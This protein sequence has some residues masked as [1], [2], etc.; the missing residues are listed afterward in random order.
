MKRGELK[1]YISALKASTMKYVFNNVMI[2]DG[3][4]HATN[5]DILVSFNGGF[6]GDGCYNL[7]AL[8]FY[9]DDPTLDNSA[10]RTDDADQFP[11]PEK[12]EWSD[13]ALITDWLRKDMLEAFK[14][15][16][17]DTTR[18]ALQ[19][20]W[21]EEFS[22]GMRALCATDGYRL[23]VSEAMPSLPD[24]SIIPAAQKVLSKVL[25]YG[26][27]TLRTTKD[28]VE[29]SNGIFTVVAKRTDFQHPPIKY[30]L[31]KINFYDRIVEVPI[32]KVMNI[33]EARD[34]AIKSDGTIVITTKQGFKIVHPCKAEMQ[35]LHGP[36]EFKPNSTAYI[37]M[38]LSNRAPDEAA[39]FNV[40]LLASMPQTEG[41]V[42]LAFNFSPGVTRA[43]IARIL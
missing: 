22:T 27:W 36:E 43:Q 31:D 1:A 16:S 41:V 38:G 42:R 4:A 8:D 5:L 15:T 12:Q 13:P 6:T 3:V 40:A 28:M 25:K 24:F 19:E 20:V 9:L 34:I 7:N 17:N 37:L 2:K 32:K 35:V 30:I 29:F 33:R 21:T 26:N 10:F 39:S 14:Y 23:F 11:E 18:P